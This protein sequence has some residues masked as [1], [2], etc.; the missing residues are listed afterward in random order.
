VTLPRTAEVVVVGGGSTGA[1]IAY[2][3]ARRG[4][5]GVLLV[6]QGSL[7]GGATGRSSAI[8]RQHY[9]YP[10]TARMAKLALEAFERFDEVIGGV[11]GFTRTGYLALVAGEDREALAGNVALQRSVGV[12]TQVV[13][14][15][16]LRELVPQMF[17]GDLAAAAYEPDAG[18]AD[19]AGT[20]AALARRARELGARLVEGVPV[21]RIAV[22]GGAVAGVETDRGPVAART[23][24]TAAGGWTPRLLAPLGV[25]V[26]ILNTL[27]QI[28]VFERPPDFAGPHPV[29]G[30]FVNQVYFR[31][32]QGGLT[33]VGSTRHTHEDVVDPDGYPEHA[34]PEWL[35]QFAERSIARFPRMEAARSRGGWAGFYDTSPDFQFILDRVPGIAGLFLACGFSGHGFKHSPILGD[36][37]ADLVLGTPPG[38]PHLDLGFFALSRFAEG[39]PHRPR[40][41]Y[42]RVLLGR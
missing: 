32:E 13:G 21:R 31:S 36:L 37:V 2:H 3:L 28:G 16:E 22:E 20:T 12:R 35:Q 17:T 7:A 33:L 10:V 4:V 23:V 19:P 25:A 30:D 18:Y 38:D 1:S 24:V 39:R 8:V 27:H 15:A 41:A 11:S 9:A 26:P 14:P 34:S 5:R 29:C 42:S 40:H 6:E